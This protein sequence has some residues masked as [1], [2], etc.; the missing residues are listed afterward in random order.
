MIEVENTTELRVAIKTWQG[1][2]DGHPEGMTQPNTIEAHVAFG[3]VMGIAD[4]LSM[5]NQICVPPGATR[6]QF[7][8]VPGKYLDDP[9]T[10][11]ST[12]PR[13]T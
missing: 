13:P 11:G 7:M 10:S 1:L 3:F 8:A 6:A 5:D 9:R 12:V 4:T 2:F